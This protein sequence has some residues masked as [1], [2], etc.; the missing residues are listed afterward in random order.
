ML[1]RG[2][3]EGANVRSQIET[4]YVCDGGGGL[5]M[6]VDEGKKK[7][8]RLW[9]VRDRLVSIGREDSGH[10]QRMNGSRDPERERRGHV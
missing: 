5:V 10:S 3:S 6:V 4:T 2:Q 1:V 9:T 7:G 8:T